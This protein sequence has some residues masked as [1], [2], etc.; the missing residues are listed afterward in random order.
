MQR[1]AEARA[2]EWKRN[3]PTKEELEERAREEQATRWKKEDDREQRKRSLDL[4]EAQVKH[5]RCLVQKDMEE[6]KTEKNNES[7]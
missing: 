2:K 4:L 1:E 3:N 6:E 7:T 5:M